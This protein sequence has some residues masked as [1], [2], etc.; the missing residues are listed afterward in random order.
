MWWTHSSRY[1]VFIYPRHCRMVS[2]TCAQFVPATRQVTSPPSLLAAVMALSVIGISFSLLCS[3]TTKV[4]WNLWRTLVCWRK[5]QH[6]SIKYTCE[7]IKPTIW[8]CSLFNRLPDNLL[9]TM[10]DLCTN[11]HGEEKSWER[12]H[13]KCGFL[14]LK[15]LSCFKIGKLTTQ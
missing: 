10:N 9:T 1:C 3:A 11:Q 7:S 5:C 8:R 2:P 13:W 6:L 12:C 15:T 14:N 4:L